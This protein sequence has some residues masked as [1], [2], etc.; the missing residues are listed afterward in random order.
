MAH[1]E[2]DNRVLPIASPERQPLYI[3]AIEA[4]ETMIE[5]GDFRAGEQLPS[6]G[7]LAEMLGISRSTL[8]E[9][10][11]YLE[12]R[13]LISRRQGVGTFVTQAFGFGFLGGLERLEPFRKVMERAGIPSKVVERSVDWCQAS[14]RVADVLAIEKDS[15]LVQVQVVEAIKGIRSMYIESVILPKIGVFKALQAYAGS[16]IDFLKEYADQP[17]SHTRT[18]IFSVGVDSIVAEK[19]Y[20]APGTPTLHLVETY[21]SA[22]GMA[23]GIAF[24]YFLTEHFHFYVNRRVAGR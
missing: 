10:L 16:E 1:G 11:G 13:G 21:Y 4:L 17:L 22:S 7:T 6:E 2:K 9:A 3:R 19:L 24:V 18:E 20:I 15:E 12:T 8:R 5:S 14:D 23:L